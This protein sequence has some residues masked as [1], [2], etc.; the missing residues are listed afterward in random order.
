MKIEKIKMGFIGLGGRGYALLEM[1]LEDFP[2]VEVVAA[3]DSYQDRTDAACKL[4]EEKRGAAASGY[5]DYRELLKDTNINTVLISAAWEAHVPIAVVAMRAGKITAMEVGGAYSIDDCWRLV[6]TQQE[7]QM[8]FMFLENCC[9]GKRELLATALVRKGIL[10]EVVYCHGAYAHDLRREVAYGVQNR[11]YRLRNYLS[12]N[13]DNYPTHELGPIAKILNINRG[14]RMLTLN[15]VASKARGLAEYV[16]DKEELADLQ[17]V[18]FAQG[19]IV[20]THITCADGSL[21]SLKLSTTLP[22]KYSRELTVN[23]TKGMYC[24]NGEYVLEEGK[25]KHETP[26]K[27]YYGN[28]ENYIELMPKKWKEQDEKRKGYG[29]ESIDFITLQAFF[30]AIEKGEEMPID[31]YD[32]A[33]WM[34]VSCLSELSIK[35]NGA[36]V[37]IP[38]FTSGAWVMREPKDVVDFS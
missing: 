18:T 25:Y 13:C 1:V 4:I 11:H 9:Y 17:G 37:E 15:S 6:R 16:K 24:E 7:T 2:Q 21:I 20:E 36:P 26:M 3:C 5:T 10:G 22:H 31:V 32:A 30:E 29:H 35:N 12:R 34:S 23:G 14:N 28:S 33:A 38:D 27:E 19:D 8:P